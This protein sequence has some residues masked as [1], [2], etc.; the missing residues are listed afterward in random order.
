MENFRSYLDMKPAHVINLQRAPPYRS[1][2]VPLYFA[3][4]GIP[5]D[6]A[7]LKATIRDPLKALQWMHNYGMYTGTY[8]NLTLSKKPM[9]EYA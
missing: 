8:V 5:K 3:P 6:L 2:R 1:A 7:D 4:C 9:D